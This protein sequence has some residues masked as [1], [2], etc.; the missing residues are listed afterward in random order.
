MTPGS[1]ADATPMQSCGPA[2]RVVPDAPPQSVGSG[3]L[4][5]DVRR[6]AAEVAALADAHDALFARTPS[7]PIELSRPWLETYLASGRNSGR[8][9]ALTA[10]EGERLVGLL[11]LAVRSV[12]GVK[13]ATPVGTGPP[14]SH[15]GLLVEPG[16]VAAPESLADLCRAERPFD[17]LAMHDVADDDAATQRW[18][19]CLAASGLVVRRVPR[20]TCW[21]AVLGQSLDEFLAATKSAKSRRVLRNEDRKLRNA[22]VVRL[23]SFHGPE[24]DGSVLDRVAAVQAGSWMVRR[25]APTLAQPFHRRLV[26]NL[27]GA[28]SAR[29]L[30]ATLDGRDAACIVVAEAHGRCSGLFMAFRLEHAPLSIGKWILIRTIEDACTIGA[31]T[32]DFGQGDA[33]YKRFWA[34]DA[35]QIERVFVG[36]GVLGGLVARGLAAAWNLARQP[37]VRAAIR[38][39]RWLLWRARGGRPVGAPSTEESGS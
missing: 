21:R 13:V 14:T 30:I 27:A 8:P 26:L 3:R 29:A 1:A 11:L 24:I 4:R 38:R 16:A 7:A 15:L 10:W 22:G 34:N 12:L 17:V 19:T 23:E 20:T 2:A 18:V 9:V 32:F 33:E 28:C 39:A 36:R 25:G 37:R 35:H 5:V 6:G 31:R